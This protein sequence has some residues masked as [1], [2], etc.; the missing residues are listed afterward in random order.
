MQYDGNKVLSKGSTLKI[1]S[2]RF[3]DKVS[4]A[5]PYERLLSQVY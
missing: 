2:F 5:K 4:D 1:L 3:E